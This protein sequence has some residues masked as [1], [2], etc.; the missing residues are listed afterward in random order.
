MTLILRYFVTFINSYHIKKF[1]VICTH[2]AKPKSENCQK[3]KHFIKNSLVRRQVFSLASIWHMEG[4]QAI[5]GWTLCMSVGA[6][7]RVF[8]FL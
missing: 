3:W 5:H 4:G 8:F 1:P 6:V 2:F 7:G